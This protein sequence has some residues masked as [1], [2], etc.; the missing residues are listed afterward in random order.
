MARKKP[1]TEVDPNLHA[2]RVLIR[3]VPYLS[4]DKDRAGSDIVVE[5]SGYGPGMPQ[6]EPSILFAGDEIDASSDEYKEAQEEFKRG[7]VIH[8]MDHDYYRL[9]EAGAVADLGSEPP[10]VEEE[11]GYLDPSTATVEELRQWI[12]ESK[13]NVQEVIDASDGEPEIASKLLEAESQAHDGEPRKGVMDALS[14][15]IS[16]G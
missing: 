10:S 15:V 1:Q 12:S 7:Q 6:I 14:V 5:K 11:E 13:P 9:I 8:L 16:R 3:E 2:V 4:R